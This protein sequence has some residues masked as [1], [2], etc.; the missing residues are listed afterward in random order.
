MRKTSLCTI[1]AALALFAISAS[2]ATQ[3]VPNIWGTSFGSTVIGGSFI[4]SSDGLSYPAVSADGQVWSDGT[5]LYVNATLTNERGET[6]HLQQR[7]LRQQ[8]N[9]DG[10]VVA[11]QKHGGGYFIVQQGSINPTDPLNPLTL[12]VINLPGT[13]G[14]TLNLR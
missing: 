5:S 8:V 10:T 11:T 13:W 9:P 6:A 3:P 4:A 12:S 2:A 1:G 7:L 14:Y